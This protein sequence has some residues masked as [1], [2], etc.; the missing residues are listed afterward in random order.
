MS[1]TDYRWEYSPLAQAGDWLWTKLVDPML[2]FG[3]GGNDLKTFQRVRAAIQLTVFA[4]LVLLPLSFLYKPA[5]ML[6]ACGLLFD[7]A[8]VMRIF[9]LERI[10]HELSSFTPKQD[11]T[12]PS[13]AMR[14]LLMPEAVRMMEIN[15]RD[16]SFFYYKQRGVVFLFVGFVLQMI[17]DWL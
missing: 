7:I 2:R 10:D 11:G 13:V 8:G 12:Y 15:D 9:L 17:G 3:A 6:T 16:I 1:L 5:H 4:A 14:E